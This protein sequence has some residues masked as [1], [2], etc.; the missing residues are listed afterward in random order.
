MAPECVQVKIDIG[1]KSVCRTDKTEEGYTHDWVVFVRGTDGSSISHFVE[2]VVFHLHESFPKPKRVIKLPPYK[3]EESGYGS[4]LLLI[5]IYFKNKEEPKKVKF[6]YDLYLQLVGNPPVTNVRVEVLTFTD[7]VEDFKKKLLKGGG[8]VVPMSGMNPPTSTSPMGAPAL[9]PPVSKPEAT[10]NPQPT[11][12]PPTASPPPHPVNKNQKKAS[13]PSSLQQAITHGSKPPKLKEKDTTLQNSNM[14]VKRS[15]TEEIPPTQ[16]LKKKKLDK[17]SDGTSKTL[18][19]EVSILGQ[20]DDKAKAKTQPLVAKKAE[21]VK[22][23]RKSND[24]GMNADKSKLAKAGKES[25]KE[26]G[27]DI[28]G[29]D[30]KDKGKKDKIKKGEGADEPKV[31]KL[32]VKRTSTDAWASTSKNIGNK[33]NVLNALM[34]EL[35][36]DNSDSDPE[37][38]E[39]SLPLSNKVLNQDN[40]SND[41]IPSN[42]SKKLSK[43]KGAP[44]TAPGTD[45]LKVNGTRKKDTLSPQNGKTGGDTNPL[46][47]LWK[48]ISTTEDRD[49]LQRIVD[50]VESTGKFE[51]TDSTFD[52]DLCCLDTDTIEKLRESLA[53]R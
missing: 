5:E 36:A 30:L 18:P 24:A 4:F 20:S 42:K 3:V 52:F 40:S 38:L 26:G 51:V 22:E 21:E 16:K 37:D 32:T 44:N 39:D 27:K 48:R 2:K 28:K 11:F 17:S 7:P 29:K 1:H 14:A 49:T 12:S 15:N 8:M 50:I 23:R 19:K 33:D 6:E 31:Q 34:S 43:T 25:K 45:S 47:E 46:V 41:K 10:V 53:I 9:P 13:P 35:R